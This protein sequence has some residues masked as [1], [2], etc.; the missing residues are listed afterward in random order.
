M[1]FVSNV[2]AM[3]SFDGSFLG[4]NVSMEHC[5]MQTEDDS[6]AYMGEAKTKYT[7]NKNYILANCKAEYL[8]DEELEQ[9]VIERADIPC[10]IAKNNP[11]PEA[12]PK[13]IHYDG[14]GGF[15][16]TPSGYVIGHCRAEK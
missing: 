1:L 6:F 14:M 5:R 2:S 15:T 3:P 12:R 9:A 13:M 4:I 11:D 8:Q 16:V 7:M 10:R